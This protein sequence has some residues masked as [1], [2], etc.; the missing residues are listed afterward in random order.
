MAEE[1]GVAF[2]AVAH[3]NKTSEQDAL[4]RISGGGAFG[5]APRSV[6][7]V[8]E[9][10]ENE[11]K[12]LFAQIKG[13]LSTPPPPLAYWIDSTDVEGLRDKV[14]V[15]AW[16]SAQT[17]VDVRSL[18]NRRNGGDGRRQS[19][20]GRARDLV[21][22]MVGE[23][24]AI[25]AKLVLDAAHTLGID[26]ST[27]QRARKALGFDTHKLGGVWYWAKSKDD[28]QA[29]A[30]AAVTVPSVSPEKLSS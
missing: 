4:H 7:L 29:A 3:P 6:I 24:R 16:G 19:E 8:A 17:G 27:L 12:R 30:K 5:A 21:K 26:D 2:V 25:L 1:T 23:G 15:I 18:L 20:A 13:N 14:G 9:D 11:R 10:P 22:E 28:A